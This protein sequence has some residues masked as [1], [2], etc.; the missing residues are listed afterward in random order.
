MHS[1]GKMKPTDK[2]VTGGKK[3]V[4]VIVYPYIA[5]KRL[6]TVPPL[7]FCGKME[8]LLEFA[9]HWYS[10]PRATYLMTPDLSR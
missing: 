10:A 3:M 4:G 8:R 6:F 2:T 1:S 5:D 7:C 9:F